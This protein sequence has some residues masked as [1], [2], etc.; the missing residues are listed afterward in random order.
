MDC[1]DPEGC[2]VAVTRLVDCARAGRMPVAQFPAG[3]EWYR[4]YDAQDGYFQANPGYGDTRF[5]PFD[6]VRTGARVPTL[7]LAEDL[8]SALLETS[9]HNVAQAHPR[10]VDERTLLGKLHA[11]IRTPHQLRLADLR[12]QRLVELGVK[13]SGIASSDPEHYPCTRTVAREIH[14]QGQG[15]TALQGI[16]WHSRQAEL[17]GTP[18]R[19]V[20]VLFA[21]RIAMGRGVWDLAAS[22]SASGA[23]LEG[24]GRLLL[25]RLADA[26]SVDIETS[27]ELDQ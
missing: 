22:R 12:D 15:G 7:Y 6:A 27:E 3:R 17:A 5:A 8:E 18:A 13:R 2:P 24:T 9:L 4:V 23:L 25:D 20:V 16:V 10:I 11:R 19:E 1:P 26:L 14:T 21:D